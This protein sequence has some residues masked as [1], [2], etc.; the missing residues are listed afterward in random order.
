MKKRDIFMMIKILLFFVLPAYLLYTNLPFDRA[1][2]G[3]AF[4][5][6]IATPALDGE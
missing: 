1:T 4:W 6:L 2:P 5:L 3:L